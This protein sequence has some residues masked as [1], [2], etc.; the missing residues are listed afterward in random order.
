MFFSKKNLKQERMNKII[1]PITKKSLLLAFDHGVEHGP[2]EYPN[3]NLHPL[4]I[5][6]I[7]VNGG[8]NGI[9]VHAGT[10]RVIKSFLPKNFAL[11]IK[12]T[13]R[14]S[15]APKKTE[16]Q[17]VVTS[18]DEAAKLGADAVAYT[19][20]VGADMEYEMIKNL[21]EVKKRCLE[22]EMPLTGFLYP[23]S[24]KLKSKYDPKAVRYAARVGA[25]LGFDIVK[26][27]YTG[28]KET[29]VD[30]VKDC[31]V[32]I[33]VAG[34][35]ETKTKGEFLQKVRDVME[36]GASGL[37]VGR[38]IWMREDGEELLREVRRIVHTTQT[39]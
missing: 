33:L 12:I 31:F 6:S 17:E 24:R 22:L 37:A 36:A 5:V 9:I 4:R 25:E 16:V 21:A 20:Y 7:A 35:P 26:T 13:G 34:G 27:Y 29:F 18:V 28:K 14:T 3:I 30:V 8:A 10:A 39:F 11:I 19:L 38:N 1:D 2:H 32:P 23:R 15:L